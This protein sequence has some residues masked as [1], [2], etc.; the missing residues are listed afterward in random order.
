MTSNRQEY[1][2][3]SRK[4]GSAAT[5]SFLDS[6]LKLFDRMYTYGS[7]CSAGARPAGPHAVCTVGGSTPFSYDDNGNMTVNGTRTVQYNPE[8]K[9]VEI[10][11]DPMSSQGNDT[12]T[13]DFMYGADGNR[14]VQ[15]V[16]SG[17]TAARTVYVGLGATGKSMYERTTT[18]STVQQTGQTITHVNFIYTGGGNAFAVRVMADDGTVTA[19]RY[20]NFDHLGSTTAISDENGHIANATGPDAGVLGYDPWGARRNPDGQPANPAS[21]NPQ[22]GHREFTGHEAIPDVGLV[23][24]C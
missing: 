8:N 11:S 15:Q 13:V 16:T 1:G 7:G 12:G 6:L 2:K 22:V 20:F 23:L 9:P 3:L 19:N 18:Q 14:V 24:L 5:E 17:T 4:N 10:I 21:F